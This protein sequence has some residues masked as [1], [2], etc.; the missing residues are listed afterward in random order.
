M[1]PSSILYPGHSKLPG[2]TKERGRLRRPQNGLQKKYVVGADT[3][4][5]AR[6]KSHASRTTA[7][8]APTE[9]AW[10]TKILPAATGPFTRNRDLHNA[11]RPR[12]VYGRQLRCGNWGETPLFCRRKTARGFRG[13]TG[14]GCVTARSSS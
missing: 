1:K 3:G 8:R 5:W 12:V 7:V 11:N 4:P 14:V 10:V 13:D 9:L 6:G 2:V